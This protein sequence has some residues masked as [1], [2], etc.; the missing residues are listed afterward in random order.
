MSTRSRSQPWFR[1]A[2]TMKELVAKLDASDYASWEMRQIFAGPLF[3]W[4]ESPPVEMR[5]PTVAFAQTW[6]APMRDRRGRFTKPG[7][8]DW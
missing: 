1:D 7:K 6:G 8:P 3:M 2:I 5:P 4:S